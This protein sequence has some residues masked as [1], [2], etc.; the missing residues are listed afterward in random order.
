MAVSF[1]RT[2]TCLHRS[3]RLL[4]VVLILEIGGARRI[5]RNRDF[6][7]SFLSVRRGGHASFL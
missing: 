3:A 6:L 5:A 4:S 2:P 7:V 1:L